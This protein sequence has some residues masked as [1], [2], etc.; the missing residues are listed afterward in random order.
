M[1]VAPTVRNAARSE[2]KEMTAFYQRAA[3]RELAV[4]PARLR[5][6][7][8]G[9]ADYT[10]RV[11]CSLAKHLERLGA[12]Q[13][14]VLGFF[15]DAG[16]PGPR[17]ERLFEAA[18]PFPQPD[19]KPR[20]WAGKARLLRDLAG[21]AL[22]MRL[23][24]PGRNLVVPSD[25]LSAKQRLYERLCLETYR[26]ELPRLLRGYDLYHWHCFSPERLPALHFFPKGSRVVM[27]IWGSDLLRTSGLTAY[28]I[29]LA[30]CQ[31]VS[32]V[33]M[34][35]HELRET[36]LAKFGR[37]LSDK[38]RLAT[39]GAD[40]LDFSERARGSRETFLKNVTLPED[41]V[42]VCVG[43]NASENNQHLPVLSRLGTLDRK[44]LETIVLLVP[45]TYGRQDSYFRKVKDAI[46]ALPVQARILDR[47]M[48]EAEVGQL[49]AASDILIHVPVTDQFSAAMCESLCAGS[50]L[51]TGAW[52][53][54]SRLRLNKIH[55]HEVADLS[56]LPGAL[57]SV[58]L[59]LADERTRTIGAGARIRQFM[60]WE[61]AVARW[62]Q[63]YRELLS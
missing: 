18:A 15:A 45:M 32:L 59:N 53:P 8:I 25:G 63:I 47:V 56:D 52:L 19:T 60:S 57:E 10:D 48:T 34:G 3:A 55:Y 43:V 39:Y 5:I 16:H 61:N 58:L 51:I 22:P 36:F 54:Y 62:D 50:I 33:T 37:G 30:A 12:Y 31:R 23:R 2:G 17:D 7:M 21:S 4:E 29:Q 14:S 26:H 28:R 44:L 40:Y 20:T 27:T 46:D 38:V 13:C 1:S 6:L 35:S 24:W 9:G 41:K 42:V 49:R 11:V